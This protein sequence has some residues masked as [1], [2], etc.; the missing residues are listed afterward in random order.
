[1]GARQ[2]LIYVYE[3]KTTRCKKSYIG[4]STNPK[5][6]LRQHKNEAKKKWKFL[7][8]CGRAVKRYGESSFYMELLAKTPDRTRAI[9]LEA[10]FIKKRGLKRTWNSNRGGVYGSGNR[11]RRKIL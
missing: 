4:L 5:R 11:H 7:T 10:K 9:E 6:R 1:M 3:L 2:F 8:K